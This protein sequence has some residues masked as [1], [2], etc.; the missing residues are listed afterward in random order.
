MTIHDIARK[1]GVPLAVAREIVPILRAHERRLAEEAAAEAR[2]VQRA[3][4]LQARRVE[5]A[6]SH[7]RGEDRPAEPMKWEPPDEDEDGAA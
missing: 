5:R 7:L 2:R 3:P 1:L 6:L 4:K